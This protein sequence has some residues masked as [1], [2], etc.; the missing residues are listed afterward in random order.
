MGVEPLG[1][2]YGIKPRCYWQHFGNLM[3]TPWEHD[4]NTLGTKGKKQK[5]PLPHFKKK[6]TGPFM[7]ACQAFPLAALNFSFQSCSLP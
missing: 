4:R 6:E 1:K 3:R 7:S 5:T 2:P